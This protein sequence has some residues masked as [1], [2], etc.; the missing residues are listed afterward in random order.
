MA[1]STE[2]VETRES[3]NPAAGW[4]KQT[5]G[6]CPRYTDRRDPTLSLDSE[7]ADGLIGVYRNP[8]TIE[9]REVVITETS[10]IARFSD[11][12][13]RIG[14]EDIVAVGI[15]A[16]GSGGLLGVR[17]CTGARMG[18]RIAGRDRA[19]EDVYPFSRFLLRVA[20]RRT[21]ATDQGPPE[22]DDEP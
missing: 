10:I 3:E 14:Y 4:A 8:D 17:L 13:Q 16:R 6:G 5:I 19:S 21:A 9:P 2:I 20:A 11:R 15:P 22:S 7:L 1:S 12:Q 18:L